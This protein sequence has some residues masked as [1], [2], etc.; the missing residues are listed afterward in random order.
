ML[1]AD[2]VR[3]R[4]RKGEVTPTYLDA[5]HPDH[6]KLASLLIGLFQTH[7]GKNRGQLDD[8]MIAL[9]G[10]GTDFLLQRG[11]AKLLVD[12]ST[13]EVDAP[14]DPI[15]LRR[16][17][18]EASARAHPVSLIPGDLVH[19][20]TRADVIAAVAADLSVAPEIAERALYADLE[21]AL[22]LRSFD[23]IAADALLHRY[24]LALAQAVLLRASS[25]TLT[26]AA[27]DP[28]RYRQLFRFIKFYRLMHVVEGDRERGYTITLDGPASMFQ[29]SSKYG[30]QMAEFLPA[31]VLCPGW[32]MRA[33]VSWGKERKPAFFRLDANSGL[34]SHYPDKGVWI[35]DEERWFVERF[36]ATK[37]RWSLEKK[38]EIIDLGGKGV[39][40]PD[41]VVRNQD[42]GRE[43]LLEI[44]GFW[45]KGYLEA[46]L[47]MLKLHGPGNL[48]LAVSK[49]LRGSEEDLAEVP[50]EVFFFKDVILTKEVLERA[51][52][53]AKAPVNPVSAVSV[54][55][56]ARKAR[57]KPQP[58]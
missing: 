6:R 34:T 38:P 58:T 42:D 35:T 2:L 12:R 52:R 19:T 44:V 33:E 50:G 7:I 46:R 25:L 8:A 39:L 48:I 10:E 5:A 41:F 1:T 29:L 9:I 21:H 4:M 16:R 56:A 54:P 32:S 23:P 17:I 37:S 30:L 22:I 57:T 14:C 40:I 13:F 36:A 53:I 3:A 15:E 31:L 51:E 18:W 49:R 28:A 47:E 43:A 20:V 24:N 11:I 27:G 26:I 55:R 45:R